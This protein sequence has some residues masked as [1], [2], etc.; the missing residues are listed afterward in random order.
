MAGYA[1][2]LFTV[3]TIF[4]VLNRNYFLKVLLVMGAVIG[5]TAGQIVRETTN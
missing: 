2:F 1:L 5:M 4:K 3:L